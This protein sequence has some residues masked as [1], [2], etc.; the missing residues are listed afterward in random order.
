MEL[1]I[2]NEKRRKGILNYFK[3]VFTSFK[4][5]ELFILIKRR[6]KENSNSQVHDHWANRNSTLKTFQFWALLTLACFMLM[7][8][9]LYKTFSS[10]ELEV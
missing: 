8:A 5:F 10:K 9:Q 7:L 6:S 3:N 1:H 2:S 4:I